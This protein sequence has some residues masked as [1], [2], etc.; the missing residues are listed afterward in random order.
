MSSIVTTNP[1]SPRITAA[2]I[3][4]ARMNAILSDRLPPHVILSNA[5]D[6]PL[7][8]AVFMSAAAR[9]LLKS[10]GDPSLRS[11]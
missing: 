2:K 3:D 10:T 7:N 11:G 8:S 4:T 9:I 6:L 5:K 1:D